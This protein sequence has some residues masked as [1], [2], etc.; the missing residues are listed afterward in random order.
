[1]F[2]FD[3]V[4]CDSLG[5]AIA[6]FNDL[7]SSFP[8]LP[9]IATQDD[10]VKV[11]S[12]SL[13]TCLSQ[14]LAAPAQKEFF[15]AH[16]RQMSYLSERLP[17]YAGVRELLA[18]VPDDSASIITSAYARHVS[19]VL[20]RHGVAPDRLL[21]I[22]GREQKKSKTDK[23]RGILES[24]SLRPD[25]ALYVGDLES[26][27]LYCRDVP[28]DIVAVTYGYHPRWHLA[29]CQPQYLVDSVLELRQ[30]LGD[31]TACKSLLQARTG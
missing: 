28:I 2:D 10:M 15:D 24:L 14:W 26:D 25:E 30:L 7:R 29:T 8:A 9:E 17:L 1:M 3:G 16:S 22:A 18:E 12:G 6:V 27:I 4:L 5:A 11:Y 13:R 19:T 23:I 31:L 21:A 20:V